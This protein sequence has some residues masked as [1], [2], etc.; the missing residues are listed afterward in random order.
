MHWLLRQ[1]KLGFKKTGD[2]IP[3]CR[4]CRFMG[5]TCLREDETLKPWSLYWARNTIQIVLCL[6]SLKVIETLKML[7]YI[8][9]DMI[10]GTYTRRHDEQAYIHD[11]TYRETKYT[12]IYM[13]RWYTGTYTRRHDEKHRNTRRP[14]PKANT[15]R[16]HTQG[17]EC[18]SI[19]PSTTLASQCL[20]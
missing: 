12:C 16:H 15:R 19:L 17:Y 20:K 4:I 3:E 11:F 1:Y 13:E 7:V 10:Q 9:R 2:K 14:D 5:L 8:H 6:I 18:I